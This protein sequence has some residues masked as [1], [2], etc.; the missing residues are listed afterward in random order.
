MGMKKCLLI[1]GLLVV[2]AQLQGMQSMA[3]LDAQSVAEADRK[4]KIQEG[5]INS[6]EKMIADLN[7]QND[8]LKKSIF[9]GKDKF[10]DRVT[11]KKYIDAEQKLLEQ[12]KNLVVNQCRLS[13]LKQV[14]LLL[15]KIDKC[16][17]LA[18]KSD[19]ALSARVVRVEQSRV[20]LKEKNS[21]I[22]ESLR[23]EGSQ[24][25]WMINTLKDNIMKLEALHAITADDLNQIIRQNVKLRQELKQLRQ[26]QPSA[27]T[28]FMNY[29]FKSKKA[30]DEEDIPTYKGMK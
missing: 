25:A 9:E 22:V 27:I 6:I 30:T 1:V 26:P 7:A 4:I 13:T 11:A 24:D 28:R 8:A 2:G 29:W 10:V 15:D 3:V 12:Q 18:R 16:E 19:E 14:K 17:E 21:E 5:V 20:K 23:Q